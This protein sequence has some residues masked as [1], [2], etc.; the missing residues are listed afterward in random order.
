MKSKVENVN[1]LYGVKAGEDFDVIECSPKECDVFE[2]KFSLYVSRGS[3]KKGAADEKNVKK[4]KMML[5]IF[6]IVVATQ[7]VE[8]TDLLKV[9]LEQFIEII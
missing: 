8:P 7:Y 2:L 4:L 1:S 5:L 9:L 6:F 3:S